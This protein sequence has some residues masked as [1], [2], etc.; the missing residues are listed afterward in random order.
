MDQALTVTPTQPIRETVFLQMIY[1]MFV[2]VVMF[3]VPIIVMIIC[4][5]VICVCLL[6]RKSPGTRSSSDNYSRSKRRV[7]GHSLVPVTRYLGSDI[8]HEPA[9][10]PPPPRRFYHM[11]ISGYL[12]H[13]STQFRLSASELL[14][15]VSVGWF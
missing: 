5:T 12:D 6:M 11:V 1:H 3:F 13:Q 9:Y 4:Y 15:F 8:D 7:S 14:L 10:T 2:A